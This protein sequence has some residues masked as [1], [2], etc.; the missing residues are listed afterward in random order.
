MIA[1]HREKL[2]TFVT[3]GVLALFAGDRFVFSPLVRDWKERTRRIAELTK[4]LH[5][6]QVLLDRERAIRD[7]WAA[8]K[9]NALPGDT[10]VAQDEVVK[11]AYRWAKDSG[12]G[13]NGITPQRRRQDDDYVTL[14]FRVEPTG[15]IESV[16]K[17]LQEVEK[18]PLA[19]KVEDLEI[20][21]KD[22]EGKLLSLGVR[23]SGLLLRPEQ[24]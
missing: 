5:R 6:G 8:M 14:E 1:K 9:T 10:S 3:I 15:D 11:A 20:T 22:S 24:R 7:R 2:L 16:A 19:L 23:F 4:D 13:F 21:A 17:F 18:D 12:I